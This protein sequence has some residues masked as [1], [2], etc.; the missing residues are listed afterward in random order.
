MESPKEIELTPE[1]V[2]ALRKLVE[3][4]QANQEFVQQVLTAGERRGAELIAE[5][6][7]IW[8]GLAK[9]Y[10]LDLKKVGYEPRDG[11]LVPVQWRA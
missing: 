8:D 3:K 7:A 1:E 2:S 9:K 6:R 11:K 5:G 10:G 4:Q